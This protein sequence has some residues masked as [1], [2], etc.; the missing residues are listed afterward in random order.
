MK[1]GYVTNDNK[2]DFYYD[3]SNNIRVFSLRGHK[4]NTDYNPQNPYS[5]IFVIGGIVTDEGVYDNT[6][7]E[8]L[9]ALSLPKNINEIKLKHIIKGDFHEMLDSRKIEV[10]LN[11]LLKSKYNIHYFAVNTVYWSFLDL[12][13]DAVDYLLKNNAAEYILIGSKSEDDVRAKIDYFKSCLYTLIRVDK[14]GFLKY[15]KSFDYPSISNKDASRF[16]RGLHKLARKNSNASRSIENKLP[17]HDD[18]K[19]IDLTRFLSKCKEAD[20]IELTFDD[21]IDMLIGSFSSFY[22]NRMMGFKNSHHYLDKED[23]IEPTIE[24]LVS[25][26]PEG[27]EVNEF[28]ELKYSFID[29]ENK[30]EIQLSDVVSGIIRLLYSYVEFSDQLGIESFLM[31][32]NQQQKKNLKLLHENILMAE[33]ECEGFIYRVQVPEDE[34]KMSVLFSKNV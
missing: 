28:S 27:N 34:Y 29:S 18:Y 15:I 16:F 1:Y 2:Y 20:S 4:Y 31:T 10:F 22:M 9:T 7:N 8:M 30:L 33:A 24:A 12:I 23:S 21:E 14:E 5:P 3:E 11:W 17:K 25:Y 32:A 6:L 19:L 26:E 13:E